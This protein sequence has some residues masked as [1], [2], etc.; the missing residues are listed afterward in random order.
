ME[1]PASVQHICLRKGKND[2]FTDWWQGSSGTFFE[3]IADIV[4]NE[5]VKCVWRVGAGGAMGT[6]SRKSNE[7]ETI[8]DILSLHQADA[9][10]RTCSL[11][12]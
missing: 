1:T 2:M 9:I 11:H 6:E 5:F 3:G 12:Q 8:K 10:D 4:Q 7:N